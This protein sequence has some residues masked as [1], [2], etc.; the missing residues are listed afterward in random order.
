MIRA[1]I[2]GFSL[3]A[4]HRLAV[5][6]TDAGKQGELEQ[7]YRREH[8]VEALAQQQH[9]KESAAGATTQI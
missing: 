5:D 4:L 3:L 9:E 6:E 2:I 1:V 7:Q 8:E